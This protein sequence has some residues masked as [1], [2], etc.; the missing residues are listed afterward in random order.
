MDDIGQRI[1]KLRLER[2]LTQGQLAKA[3][4]IT[5]GS[6]TQLETGKSK[7]PASTTLTELARV[8]E[9]DPD[10]LMTG[11]GSPQAPVALSDKEAELVLVFRELST[12][13]QDYVIGRAK[14]VQRDERAA[15]GPRR[16]TTDQPPKVAPAKDGS[17]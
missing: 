12:E 7:S 16:R 11:K 2:K 9:V 10:W 13:G 5:Q 15:A 8:F 1:R 6:L 14:S 3:I 4:G 17:H